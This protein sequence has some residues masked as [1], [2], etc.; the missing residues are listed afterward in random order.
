MSRTFDEQIQITMGLR[1]A[2]SN[3]EQTRKI[4]SVSELT[5]Q[6]RRLLEKSVG[7][8]WVGG[9]ITN[10]RAQ[11]SGHVYFTLKDVAAQSNC[12]LFAGRK[13]AQRELLAD[14][15]KSCCKAT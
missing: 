7:S 2:V 14:G 10:L 3:L 8:I 12:V 9:E 15:Q 6:V 11:S 1:R 5:A 13:V 4:L